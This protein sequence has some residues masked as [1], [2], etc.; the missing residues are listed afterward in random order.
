MVDQ[1]SVAWQLDNGDPGSHS[2]ADDRT[3][4]VLQLMYQALMKIMGQKSVTNSDHH[5]V[6]NDLMRTK[7]PRIVESYDK[8]M[9]IRPAK[10]PSNR[11]HHVNHRPPADLHPIQRWT[12]KTIRPTYQAHQSLLNNH[13]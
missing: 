4:A 2:P 3:P 7:S 13:H 12:S 11:D 6:V 10:Q 9:P 8:A 5:F 1:R